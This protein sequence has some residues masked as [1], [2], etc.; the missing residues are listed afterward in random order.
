[1]VYLL[2]QYIN[3]TEISVIRMVYKVILK[4]CNMLQIILDLS[5]F[6]VF[7]INW[8]MAQSLC[9]YTPSVSKVIKIISSR[10]FLWCLQTLNCF[11]L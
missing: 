8:K 7:Y 3:H 1:M 5:G 9:P 4:P 10:C 6:E 11:E 2:K